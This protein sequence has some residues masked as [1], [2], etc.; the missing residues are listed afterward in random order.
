MGTEKE[1]VQIGEIGVDSGLVYIG[2]PC[3]VWKEDGIAR[4]QIGDWDQFCNTLDGVP[5]PLHHAF[6][7]LGVVAASGLGDGRYPVY[8]TIEDWVIT[9][10][11]VK[12]LE[13]GD[14]PE[15]EEIDDDEQ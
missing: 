6:G 9:S 10:I 12:F 2:D 5:Y 3:Y 11:T 7:I 4:K 8:A 14:E 1:I 13:D 15:D